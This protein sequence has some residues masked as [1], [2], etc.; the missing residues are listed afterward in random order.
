M[1]M[2]HYVEPWGMDMCRWLCSLG[3]AALIASTFSACGSSGSSTPTAASAPTPTAPASPTV[4]T[5]TVSGTAPSIGAT[6]PF[7][8]TAN[9]STVTAQTVTA[10]VTWQSSSP[11]VGTVSGTGVVACMATA[12]TDITATYQNITGKAH[13]TLTRSTYTLSGTSTDGTSGGVL[14]NINVT[15]Q[16]GGT[17]GKST[18][19]DGAGTYSI[20]GLVAGTFSVVASATSYETPTSQRASRRIPVSILC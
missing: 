2:D 12:E 14:P 17:A 6:S 9:P 18:K 13:L 4:S 3:A 7:G 5:V 16:D 10:Q 1:I 15:L 19:T 8:S 20:G 11:S